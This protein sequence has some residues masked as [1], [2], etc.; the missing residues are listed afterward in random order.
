MESIAK[1]WLHAWVRYRDWFRG[2]ELAYYKAQESA[3]D[4]DLKK[5]NKII[6]DYPSGKETQSA[7]VMTAKEAVKAKQAAYD[8]AIASGKN[9]DKAS[10]ALGKARTRLTEL[11]E[12]L[13]ALE[14]E[15]KEA[16]SSLENLKA[17]LVAAKV[18]V[19]RKQAEIKKYE[20]KN[21][22]I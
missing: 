4:K 16:V 7:K 2:T 19:K 3:A 8:S 14:A 12:K 18:Q 20:D 10:E 21:S 22:G 5:A 6:N 17:L 9:A 11:T 13:A 1:V 15:Y